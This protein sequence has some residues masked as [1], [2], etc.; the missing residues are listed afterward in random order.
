MRQM[1]PN[2][3]DLQHIHRPI[4]AI[5]CFEH[6]LFRTLDSRLTFLSAKACSTSDPLT[7]AAIRALEWVHG[8]IIGAIFSL[9]PALLLGVWAARRRLLDGPERH[10]HILQRIAVLGVG[11]AAVG[12]LPWALVRTS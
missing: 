3:R 6:H 10:R 8:S 7:A 9:V 1:H 4:P 5:R 11:L 12:G 2:A